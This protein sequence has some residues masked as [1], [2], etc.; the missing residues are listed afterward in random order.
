MDAWDPPTARELLYMGSTPPI[1]P[2]KTAMDDCGEG[3]GSDRALRGEKD[4]VSGVRPGGGRQ[5]PVPSMTGFHSIN[6]PNMPCEFLPPAPTPQT[7]PAVSTLSRGQCPAQK[8]PVPSGRGCCLLEDFWGSRWGERK[9]VTPSWAL[10]G[11]R[12]DQRLGGRETLASGCSVGPLR[13]GAKV[14]K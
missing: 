13:V 12:K 14:S 2:P 5:N 3:K 6:I 9:V 1:P 8:S 10:H 4:V 7:A 11:S